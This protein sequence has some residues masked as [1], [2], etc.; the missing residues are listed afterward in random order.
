MF[1]YHFGIALCLVVLFSPGGV[2]VYLHAARYSALCDEL[3]RSEAAGRVLADR[4]DTDVLPYTEFKGRLAGEVAAGRVPLSRAVDQIVTTVTPEWRAY[5]DAQYPG[6]PL[7]QQ[8]AWAVINR[9]EG[10]PGWKENEKSI[11]HQLETMK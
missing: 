10:Y 5:L 11:L 6:L 1:V 4:A 8:V 2:L 9:A 3:G 7:R